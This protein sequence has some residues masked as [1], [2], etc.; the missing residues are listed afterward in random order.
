MYQLHTYVETIAVL[1]SLLNT[2]YSLN[3]VLA[4]D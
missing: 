2:D 4:S 3:V 1:S